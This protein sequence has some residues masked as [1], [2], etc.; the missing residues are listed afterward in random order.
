M[1]HVRA[2]NLI[3]KC[4]RVG[5]KPIEDSWDFSTYRGDTTY[6]LDLEDG[7]RVIGRRSSNG[8]PYFFVEFRRYVDLP[9]IKA[10]CKLLPHGTT[11]G[12][13]WGERI[14]KIRDALYGHVYEEMEQELWDIL[15][16]YDIIGEDGR[17]K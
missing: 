5:L 2:K 14:Y 4:K 15:L 3:E 13:K 10:L 6:T 17:V 16:K 1:I 9:K 7:V 12:T 11:Y 8:D